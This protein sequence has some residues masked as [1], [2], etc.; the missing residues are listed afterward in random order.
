MS[1]PFRRYA[2]HPADPARPVTY[3]VAVVHGGPGA[4]GSVAAVAQELG[5]DYGVL[6][7]LQ[8][9]DTIDGQA[10][11]LRATLIASANPPL[12]LIG[13]SWGAWLS[14]ITAAR[15]PALVRQVILVSS[16]PFRAE[17]AAS[18]MPTRLSRLTDEERAEVDA[19]LAALTA[20]DA[21]VPAGA[22]DRFGA[23]LKAK[24]DSYDLLP[25]EPNDL[26]AQPDVHQRMWDEASTL[27]A[28]GGLLAQVSRVQCPVLAIHG[29]HDPHPAAGVREPLAAVL[30]DFRFVLLERCGH[31]PWQERAARDV[32]FALVRQAIGTPGGSRPAQ[33]PR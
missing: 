4:P 6:E 5:H 14:L 8:T 10:A 13:W 12:T 23:L 28:S 20:P 18:I 11:E 9:A 17:D 24:T 15:F 16:G 33:N 2:P 32:F 3:R 30:G 25:D 1:G 19:L 22:L 21:D 27:R 26:P 31:Y 29:D 7:P